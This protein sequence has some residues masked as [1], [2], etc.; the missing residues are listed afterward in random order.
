MESWVTWSALAVLT[1]VFHLLIRMAVVDR[2]RVVAV[3]PA[4]P[5]ACRYCERRH[6]QPT[7]LFAP[8]A[9]REASFVF[10]LDVVYLAL[11]LAV[12]PSVWLNDVG[13]IRTNVGNPV[14]GIVPIGVL[15]AGALGGVTIGLYGVFQ[16]NDRWKPSL[17][18]WHVARPVMGALLGGVAFIVYLATVQ[19]TG[20]DG[21]QVTQGASADDLLFY[22][23]IAFVVGYRE[24]TFRELIKRA[25]DLVLKPESLAVRASLVA[26]PSTGP[27]PLDVTFDASGSVNVSRWSIDYGDGS[28]V[29]EC[30]GTPG[31][32][33]HTYEAAGRYV[34]TISVANES[35]QKAV[36]STQVVVSAPSGG[37]SAEGP[38]SSES[39]PA[40]ASGGSSGPSSEEPEAADP[41]LA[42]LMAATTDEERRRIERELIEDTDKF[43]EEVEAPDADHA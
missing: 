13:N 43:A 27:A 28:D 9:C 10:K 21:A 41:G 4:R 38:S 33:R 35:G 25:A 36:Q 14:A 30:S 32:V 12:L 26:S 15:L 11:L 19:A 17:N 34:A 39:P 42:R 16:Y 24:E 40:S 2:A 3:V 18:Y 22:Y 23:V 1:V 37:P 7:W 5:P 8:L 31:I 29:E 20:A 6:R